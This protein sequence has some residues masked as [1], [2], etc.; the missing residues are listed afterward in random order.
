MQKCLIQLLHDKTVVYVTHQLEFLDSSD[1]VL[2]SLQI[3]SYFKG[4]LFGY[5]IRLESV[6]IRF[7]MGVV[8]IAYQRWLFLS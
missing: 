8:S 6:A 2:V 5:F 1:L 7:I 4:D 3:H